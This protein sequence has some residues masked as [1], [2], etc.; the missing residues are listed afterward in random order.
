MK[1][2]NELSNSRRRFARMIGAGMVGLPLAS[3]LTSLPSRAND[4]PLLD[5]GSDAAKALQYMDVSDKEGKD[6]SNCTLYQGAAGDAAGACPLF[7]GSTVAASA[8]C[9]A[10]VPKA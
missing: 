8:W 3:L 10:W 4:A 9:S 1:T 2:E 7:Q 5:A 6:C